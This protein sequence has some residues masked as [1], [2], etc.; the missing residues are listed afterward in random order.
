MARVRNKDTKP[1]LKVRKALHAAGLRFRLQARDL[2]GR[3]DIVF[4]SRRIAI[5][6]HGCFWHRHPDPSCKLARMPKSRSEFWEP[7]LTANAARDE[8]NARALKALGWRVEL[9][10]ECDLGAEALAGLVKRVRDTPVSRAKI[11]VR[12]KG[13]DH[14]P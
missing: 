12:L 3:P 7:K 13:M 1:E 8:R 6:V 5:F 2:P 4:R 10:W 11:N 9:L 14:H